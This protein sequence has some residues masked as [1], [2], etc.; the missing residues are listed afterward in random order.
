MNSKLPTQDLGRALIQYL[1]YTS[2]HSRSVICL[3]L[4]KP[5]F[6]VYGDLC[7]DTQGMLKSLE[8]NWDENL[9]EEDQAILFTLKLRLLETFLIDLRSILKQ[10]DAGPLVLQSSQEILKQYQE[11][12]FGVS[13]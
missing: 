6:E 9:L 3:E 5:F 4:G 13:L 2:E 11:S 8:K 7:D 1:F 12:L 10:Y